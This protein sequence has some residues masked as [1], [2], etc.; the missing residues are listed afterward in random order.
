LLIVFNCFLSARQVADECAKHGVSGGTRS[1]EASDILN[2]SIDTLSPRSAVTAPWVADE[3][4][5]GAELRRLLARLEDDMSALEGAKSSSDAE[6]AR[7]AR[8][9]AASNEDVE[10]L[11]AEL[12][13]ALTAAASLAPFKQ[14]VLQ[15]L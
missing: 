11:Q 2:A 10:R 14:I 4:S 9:L 1:P 13:S 5:A 3:L 6:A 12:D 15:V 8:S 7:L